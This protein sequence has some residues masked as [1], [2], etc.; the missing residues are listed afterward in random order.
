M[1][2]K[3]MRDTVIP[4]LP[5]NVYCTMSLPPPVKTSVYLAPVQQTNH[6]SNKGCSANHLSPQPR[7]RVVSKL[8]FV[9]AGGNGDAPKSDVHLADIR[10]FP[11][12]GGAPSRIPR[13]HQDNESGVFQIAANLN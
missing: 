10:R 3:Q 4:V 12:D 7:R 5:S 13:I 11:I 9:L 6:Q 8:Y 2:P 1:H